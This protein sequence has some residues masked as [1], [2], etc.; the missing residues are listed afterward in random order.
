MPSTT[1]TTSGSNRQPV[2]FVGGFFLMKEIQR[3]ISF[4]AYEE[5]CAMGD[6]KQLKDL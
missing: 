4:R 6:G 2:E 3:N 5:V 1:T